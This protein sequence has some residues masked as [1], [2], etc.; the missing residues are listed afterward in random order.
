MKSVL[1]WGFTALS[2]SLPTLA[3]T[4]QAEVPVVGETIDVRVVNVET[5]VTNAAG[6]RVRGLAAADFRLLV[7]GRE[8]PVEYFAEV[9]DGTSVSAENA[10]VAAGEAVARNYLIYIDD[11]FS[12]ANRR[13]AVLEK[14]E[15]DLDLLG[16]ADRMAILAC[17]GARIHVLADWTGDKKI[18][19]AALA[20]ARQRPALGGEMLA[21]Q[22][23]LQADVHWIQDNSIDSGDSDRVGGPKVTETGE[24]LFW[25]SKRISPEARTE[26][27]KSTEAAAAALGGFPAP[28][29]RRMM[30]LL[31]GAWSLSVAPRLY[32]PLVRTANQL[33]YTVYPV[34]VSQ[35]D[36]T[37]DT[38]LDVLARATGGRLLNPASAA[39]FRE[40]VSDSGTYYW[41]GFTPAWKA[42]DRGHSVTVEVRR[43]GLT[44]RSRGGFSDLSRRTQAALKA[45]SVLLFGGA[46]D[47]RRLVVELGEAKRSRGA[48]EVPVTLGVPVEA[49]TLTPKGKGYIADIPLAVSTEENDGRRASLSGPHLRVEIASLPPAGTYARFHTVIR[50]SDPR[51]RMIF[52]IHDALSGHDLWGEAAA[53]PPAGHSQTHGT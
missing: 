43:T 29:G 45:E 47:D 33:G 41:L 27:G 4:P 9:A 51:Q 15:R 16:P 52:S 8:V 7:D 37:E 50:V 38:A 5:V 22:R 46:A 10:P 11:A 48:F 6:E 44:A 32:G 49:L 20:R 24:E 1:V 34:E 31:S 3:Q 53:S 25:M 13:N 42:D 35:S 17:D 2:L 12:L 14:L 40:M 26:L 39:A 30:M 18:L 23:K 19:Q 21:H 36:A 28:A